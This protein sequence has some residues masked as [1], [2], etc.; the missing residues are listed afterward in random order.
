M[1]IDIGSTRTY[2]HTYVV[3]IES[4]DMLIMLPDTQ[5]QD[6]RIVSSSLLILQNQSYLTVYFIYIRRS[7]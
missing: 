1:D 5:Q 2:V 7:I 4:G 6:P 3:R